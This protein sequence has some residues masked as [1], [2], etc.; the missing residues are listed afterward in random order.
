MGVVLCFLVGLVV[1]AMMPKGSQWLLSAPLVGRHL[2][3]FGMF[4]QT[5]FYQNEIND[6][7]VFLHGIYTPE[8]SG[9]PMVTAAI[10][11]VTYAVQMLRRRRQRAVAD[12]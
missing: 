2:Y 5:R 11:F 12:S 9:T 6:V 4:V 8:S 7:A 3:A 1:A 10:P